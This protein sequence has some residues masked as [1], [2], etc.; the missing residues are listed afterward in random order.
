MKRGG[1]TTWIVGLA[2][3]TSCG[4]RS[5]TPPE[6]HANPA[7]SWQRFSST[8]KLSDDQTMVAQTVYVPIYSSITTADNARPIN[9]AVTLTVRNLDQ[10]AQS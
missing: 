1:V 10:A 6:T 7:R 9:L 5:A 8:A 2:A 3:F 4:H